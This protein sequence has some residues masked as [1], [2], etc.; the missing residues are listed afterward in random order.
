MST[1]SAG[2]AKQ[3]GYTDVRVFL[4]GEPAWIAESLPNY[5]SM[6]FVKEGNIVLIDTRPRHDAIAAR[7]PRAVNLPYE[8]IES[9]ID[10]IPHNAPV[11]LYGGDE[12][13]DALEDLHD[14]G[15]KFVSLVE[16]GLEGWIA[17]GG[18]TVS[19]PITSTEISWTRIPGPGE[20]TTED[21]RKAASGE[22]KDA[23]II[24]ARTKEEVAELGIFRNTINIPLDEIPLRLAEI[25]KDKKIYLHCSTGARADLAYRELIKHG[26]NAKYLFLDISDP[27]C[28]CE[29]IKP[30]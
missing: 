11:V 10:D 4:D 23:V 20:V 18:Q 29:V 14:Y 17:S 25:P 9:R 21:F 26:F 12:A 22:D 6:K 13:L 7:I 27:A 8:K 28:D 1:A 5:A 19:G 15:F 3:W 30:W 2:L 24:D 16:G